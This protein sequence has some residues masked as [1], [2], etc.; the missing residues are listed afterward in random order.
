LLEFHFDDTTD[1]RL[2]VGDKHVV[3]LVG[4]S[5]ERSNQSGDVVSVAP[6]LEQ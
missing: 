1:M 6:K 2:V 4:T 5:H 3:R